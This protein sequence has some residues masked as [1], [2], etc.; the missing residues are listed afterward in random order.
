MSPGAA[1]RIWGPP[2]AW[3]LL[4]FLL[5]SLPVRAPGLS[6]PGADKAAHFVEYAV[7]GL[8]LARAL[9][10]A[11]PGRGGTRLVLLATLLGTAWGAGDE[12]HQSF[13]PERTAAWGDLLADAAGSLAGAA[14]FA[15][16][17]GRLPAATAP[18]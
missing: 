5:S 17:R 7:L 13:V 10:R 3:C 6:L 16:R 15:L 1:A 11:R 8:L 2:A 18:R 9:D 12:F 4:I 14:L